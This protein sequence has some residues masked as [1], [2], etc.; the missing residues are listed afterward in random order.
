MNRLQPTQP[1]VSQFTYWVN[2]N[3]MKDSWNSVALSVASL[4]RIF[5]HFFLVTVL[6]ALVSA[7]LFAYFSQVIVGWSGG[8]ANVA[9]GVWLGACAVPALW[10]LAFATVGG[11]GACADYA[12][13]GRSVASV[14]GATAAD[15]DFGNHRVKFA[16]KDLSVARIYRGWVFMIFTAPSPKYIV[17]PEELL[18]RDWLQ[19]IRQASRAD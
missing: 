8:A 1:S 9:V 3:S 13:V 11:F 6:W 12:T 15:I 5:G 2:K 18:P 4:P 17:L 7:L 16:Y 14:L 19:F 10:P